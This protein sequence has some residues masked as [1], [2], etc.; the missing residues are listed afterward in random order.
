VRRGA[1]GSLLLYE[2]RVSEHARLSAIAPRLISLLRHDRNAGQFGTQPTTT[3]ADTT[4]GPVVVEGTR[5]SPGPG[6]QPQP[7]L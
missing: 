5:R 1:G 7:S 3:C 6:L 4:A 2:L